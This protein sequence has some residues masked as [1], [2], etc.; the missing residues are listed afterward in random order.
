MLTPAQVK[1]VQD[2][3]AKV[4]P[5]ADKAADLFYDRLFV[6]APETRALFP[7]DLT[8]QK[9]KLMQMLATA[10]T[11][12]HQVDKIVPAVE[13]LGR[14]HATYGVTDAHYEPV[15]AALLWTLEQ[16]LGPDF[17]APVKDAWTAT[18]MTL[19]S[20]MKNAAVA[21]IAEPPVKKGVFARLFG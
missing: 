2:S 13:D 4:A 20:V 14:R 5:I 11:N 3:F 9:K 18:Y 7:E 8:A 12:L 19:S 1:L 17:T 21:A 6:I 15:G 16:G 10:V